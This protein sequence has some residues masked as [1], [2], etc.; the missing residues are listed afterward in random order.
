M[1]VSGK[2]WKVCDTMEIRS[3]APLSAS[4][5]VNGIAS[6]VGDRQLFSMTPGM[7]PLTGRAGDTAFAREGK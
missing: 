3:M 7:G 2:F 5:Y 1:R 4:R 6:R